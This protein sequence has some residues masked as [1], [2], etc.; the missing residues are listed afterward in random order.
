MWGL[1][2]LCGLLQHNYYK[3]FEIVENKNFDQFKIVYVLLRVCTFPLILTLS[4]IDLCFLEFQ[5]SFWIA[6]FQNFMPLFMD[7][8]QLPQGYRAT[9]RSKFTFYYWFPIYSWYS[10]DQP[11]KMNGWSVNLGSTEMFWARDPLGI[12]CLNH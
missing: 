12:E 9:T 5:Y 6:Y 8:V 10:F 1:L 11:R 2:K 7:G 4:P 3:T